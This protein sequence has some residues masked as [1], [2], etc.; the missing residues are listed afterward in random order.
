M[1]KDQSMS[2]LNGSVELNNEDSGLCSSSSAS[3]E[4]RLP[5]ENAYASHHISDLTPLR[6]NYTGIS[7]SNSSSAPGTFA[8]PSSLTTTSSSPSNHPSPQNRFCQSGPSGSHYESPGTYQPHELVQSVNPKDSS[9][10]K[11]KRKRGRPPKAKAVDNSNQIS[12]RKRQWH[13]APVPLDI[14]PVLSQSSTTTSSPFTGGL[15]IRLRRDLSVEEPVCG[16][17]GRAR[18]SNKKS[19]FRIVESWCDADAPGGL[20]AKTIS[21]SPMSTNQIPGG[22]RIG[23]V[24]WAKIA[25]YP[26]WPSRI[27]A[28][29]ARTPHQLAQ[30]NPECAT[31][32]DSLA[33]TATPSD[34]SLAAGF[35]AKVEWFAWDQCSYLSCAKLFPF[36]EYFS[37]LYSPRTR[38]K[39]YAEAINMAKKVVEASFPPPPPIPE[40]RNDASLSLSLPSSADIPCPPDLQVAFISPTQSKQSAIP[41]LPL[42]LHLPDP[43]IPPVGND[44]I[45]L[46]DGGNFPFLNIAGN[47]GEFD[48]VPEPCWDPLPQLDVSGLND[49]ISGVPTFSDDEGESSEALA[50]QLKTELGSI[51]L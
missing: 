7:P 22:F 40:P 13:Q 6:G 28:L 51:E 39:N 41:E 46:S 14:S 9:Q 10:W 17:R 49:F 35:T 4:A 12:S 47:P 27:S 34:P 36:T 18:K 11:T 26:H 37:K 5:S 8:L 25:G 31:S 24:V 2:V 38:V 1:A 3:N 43:T 33:V 45:N 21:A 42:D 32:S 29:Y 48:Q 15:K 20:A 19:V 50:N 16:K 23:D 44:P 30:V